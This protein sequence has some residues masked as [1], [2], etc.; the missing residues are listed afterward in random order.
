MFKVLAHYTNAGTGTLSPS[1]N[2]VQWCSAPDQSRLHQSLFEFI[3]IPK[4]Y[5]V[6]TLL[7]DSQT[8]L[9]LGATGLKTWN[10]LKFFW[11]ISVPILPVLFFPGS[12]EADIRWGGN[13]AVVWWPVVSKICAPKIIKICQSFFFTNSQTIMLGVLLD[14]F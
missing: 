14:V 8:T 12:A 4:R 9:L 7:H 2:A 1:V 10:L 11:F 6:D 13:C 3:I 5:L